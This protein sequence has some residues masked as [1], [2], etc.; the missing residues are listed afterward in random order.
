MSPRSLLQ[1]ARRE[2]LAAMPPEEILAR[3]RSG[4]LELPIIDDPVER[5]RIGRGEIPPGY[6]LLDVAGLNLSF[7]QWLAIDGEDRPTGEEP[8]E[9]WV[10]WYLD[11]RP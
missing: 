5:D 4:T 11:A 8:P 2:R 6:E 1:I 7:R 9:I 3:H 10:A